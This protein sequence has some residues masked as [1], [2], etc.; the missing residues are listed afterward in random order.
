MKLGTLC[1]IISFLAL[2][3][4]TRAKVTFVNNGYEGVTVFIAAAVRE[5]HGL[6]EKIQ[7]SLYDDVHVYVDLCVH[8]Y[9]DLCVHV[10]VDLCAHV[11]V[12]LCVH[13]GV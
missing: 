6:I 11:Y 13:E 9:V 8:V 7:V 5:D 4:R 1:S 12:D 10:Y 3:S 2:T